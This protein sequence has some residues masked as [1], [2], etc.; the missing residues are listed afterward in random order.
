MASP[1]AAGTPA[2]GGSAPVTDPPLELLKLFAS[3]PRRTAYLEGVVARVAEWTG[4][5]CAAIRTVTD[6]QEIPYLATVGFGR[7]FVRDESWLSLDRDECFCPRAV[8]GSPIPEEQP[9]LSPGGSYGTGDLQGFVRALPSEGVGLFRGRCVSEGFHSLAVVPLRHHGRSMGLLHVADR[10]PGKIDPAAILLLERIAPIIAEALERFEAERA[11]GRAHDADRALGALRA[12]AISPAPVETLLVASMNLLEAEAWLPPLIDASLEVLRPDTGEVAG[13]AV[14]HGSACPASAVCGPC[15]RITDR[16]QFRFAG[17]GPDD[18]LPTEAV[19]A[20]HLVPLAG[21]EGRAG[22]DPAVGTLRVCVSLVRRDPELE[23]FLQGAAGLLAIAV[24][25]R[26]AEGALRA[27]SQH[28]RSLIEASLDPLVTIS[29]S[30]KITDINRATEE[31]TGVPRARII[32]TD[33][34]DYFTDPEKARA[35]YRPAL[36][37]GKGRDYPLT[38][39]HAG[40]GTTDVLY[41]ASIYRNQEG[42]LQ[43]VFAAA[44]DVTELKRAEIERA[45]MEEQLRQSQKLEAVGRL[46]GGVAHDF[47]NLLTAIMGASELMLQQLPASAR[48]RQGLAEI[49]EASGRAAALTRQLLTFSRKQVVQPKVLDLNEVV[50]AMERMLRRLIGE[51]IELVV[52]LEPGLGRVRADPS[53]IEQ[54][55]VNLVVNA[56]DAMPGGGHITIETSHAEPGQGP[57]LAAGPRGGRSV[58][59]AV[60]DDGEGMTPD[61]RS[62]LFEPFFTTKG[63]GK[64][65]GLGLSTVYGVVKQAGGD[66]FVQTEPGKGSSFEVFLPRVDAPADAVPGQEVAPAPRGAEVVLLVEDEAMVRRVESETLRAL[67][68]TVLEAANGEEGWAVAGAHGGEIDLL[69]T[70]VVMPLLGG[71]ELARRMKG[72][73]PGIAILYVSGYT[74]HPEALQAADA[75]GDLLRKPFTPS[76]LAR[77]I[78]EVL[79]RRKGDRRG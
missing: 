54:V 38:N 29:P 37:A 25:R 76:A 70:D 7:E 63:S 31:V 17:L 75:E 15:P 23:I 14:F 28:A 3:C 5:H 18:P 13:S 55:I 62:H 36:A 66:V 35:G 20:I 39:R 12:L 59:L 78:R 65:T 6:S 53:Q 43:G 45:G 26:Q 52:R 48:L 1:E 10:A 9:L 69:L 44:R 47:N 61:V 67:G 60:R 27:A 64:G 21:D 50:S 24:Q 56:R 32:G 77:R 79:D 73:R 42:V 11:L 71:R 57:A 4:C 72:L 49:M 19:P 2:S 51:D 30:G 74:E 41:N 46:A 16:F 34:A 8:R 58:V 33:F 68:Y 22:T 40:G